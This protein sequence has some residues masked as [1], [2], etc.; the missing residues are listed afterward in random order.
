MDGIREA[1]Y[2][3]NG[4]QALWKSDNQFAD[5]AFSDFKHLVVTFTDGG[6]IAVYLDGLAYDDNG[7]LTGDLSG[8]TM[9]DITATT[10]WA[11]GCYWD[12]A[13]DATHYAGDIDEMRI[14]S[15]A[16]TAAEA[17]LLYQHDTL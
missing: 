6:A 7:V 11:W 17:L 16:L 15:K 13:S 8:V 10:S 14:Y 5:G 12:G 2:E 4:N 9:G 1:A 3:A